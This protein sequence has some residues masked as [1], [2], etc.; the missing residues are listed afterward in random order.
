MIFWVP[1]IAQIVI[2]LVKVKWFLFLL[3]G[4][5]AILKRSMIRQFVFFIL[6]EF[7][8][9]FFS[10]FSDFKTVIFYMGFIAMIFITK[11]YL[12]NVIYSVIAIIIL[13]YMGVMWTSIKGEYRSFLNQGSKSQNVNVGKEDALNKLVELSGNRKE[14]SFDESAADFFDRLQYTY[15]LART[16]DRVPSIIPYEGGKNIRSILEFTFTP[17]ILNPDK[18]KLEATVKT[19]KY[20]GL[21]Y[22]GAR[23][24]VSF[25][26]GYFA[27]CYIDFGYIGM[28]FPLIALGFI[29]GGLYYYFIKNSSKNFIFNY[30]VVGAMFMEFT[31]FETDGTY[32]MGRLFATSVTFLFL[33]ILFFP[34]LYNHLKNPLNVRIN[35]SSDQPKFATLQSV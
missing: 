4:F 16:M 6:L 31:A 33:K 13:F 30:A 20:T 24:G 35:K 11:V 26:L 25:S 12:R 23:S 14:G 29:F 34:W 22:L 15:H 18:P 19:T 21:S 27:D 8:M 1:S 7:S 28:F 3:F 9:G 2:S 10:Y 5:Q 17:R 32:L